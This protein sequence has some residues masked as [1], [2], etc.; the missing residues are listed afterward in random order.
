MSKQ[1]KTNVGSKTEVKLTEPVF[2]ACNGLA[3]SG[4]CQKVNLKNSRTG[5]CVAAYND[6]KK[7]IIR[8]RAQDDGSYDR[9]DVYAVWQHLLE[10]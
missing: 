6:R 8:Q 7:A 5:V 1:T 9:T 2:C 4:N 10:L 3:C